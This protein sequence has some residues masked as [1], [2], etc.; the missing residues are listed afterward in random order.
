[1]GDFRHFQV[2]RDWCRSPRDGR[3]HDFFV[4]EMPDWVQ[5]VAVTDEGRVVLVEQYR[6]GS[7][8]V[9]LEFPAGL[10]EQGEAA[11]AAAAREL[12]EETGYR[13]GEP[14][15]IADVDPNPALQ[16]NRLYVVLIEGCRATG[17][18]DEDPGEVIRVREASPSDVAELVVQERFDTAYGL[19]AW[20]AFRRYRG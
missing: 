1:V 5:I 19:V 6:P 16:D 14:V 15:V 17:E 3:S 2:R 20:E 9:T 12:A 7:R 10:V 11:A 4:L 18:R 13:G 8:R